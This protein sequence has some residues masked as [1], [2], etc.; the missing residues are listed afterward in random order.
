VNEGTPAPERS[1]GENL[2]HWIIELLL[3]P[4]LN[5]TLTACNT[6]SQTKKGSIN[7][8]KYKANEIPI[9]S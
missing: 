1:A 4:V 3:S 5:K 7:Y 9:R 2:L 6:I 8:N